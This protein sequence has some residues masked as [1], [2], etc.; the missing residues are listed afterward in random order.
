MHYADL[1]ASTAALVAGHR[2]REVTALS[3]VQ[4]E[5]MS[6]AVHTALQPEGLHILTRRCLG[7]CTED[8]LTSRC[9]S[10]RYGHDWLAGEVRNCSEPIDAFQRHFP[11]LV[12]AERVSPSNVIRISRR[13]EAKG[14]AY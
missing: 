14:E 4:T 3:P 2:L 12:V 8:D 9:K 10:E 7:A 1:H 11:G 6:V 5:Q 13:L